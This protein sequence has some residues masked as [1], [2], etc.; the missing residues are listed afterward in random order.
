ML[1]RPVYDDGSHSEDKDNQYDKCAVDLGLT[2]LWSSINLNGAKPQN[3]GGFFAWGE[4]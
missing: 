2:S 1:I 4:I 3:A